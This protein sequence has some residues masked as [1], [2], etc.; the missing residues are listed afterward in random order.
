MKL[1]LPSK[2][3]KEMTGTI[4]DYGYK[5][6]GEFVKDAIQH[7]LLALRKKGFL[8]GVEKIKEKLK[9]RGLSETEI[10]EDFEEFRHSK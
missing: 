8:E 7:R 9:E 2:L 1:D 10:L 4:K 5:D 3:K 6:T